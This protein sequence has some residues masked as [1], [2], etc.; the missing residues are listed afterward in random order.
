LSTRTVARELNVNFSTISHLNIV[1]EDL[2]ILPTGLTTADHVQPFQPRTST[3]G[4]FTSRIVRD[5]PPGQLIK[6]WVFTTKQFLHK[7]SETVSGKLICSSSS[8]GS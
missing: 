7:L 6:L 2:A 3:S 1:L 8:P 5:Q 4:F